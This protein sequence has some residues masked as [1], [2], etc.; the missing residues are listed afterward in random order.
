MLS[1][2]LRVSAAWPSEKEPPVFMEYE[3]WWARL[4]ILHVPAIE[5]GISLPLP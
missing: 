2:Q 5:P 1:G 3:V 4:K